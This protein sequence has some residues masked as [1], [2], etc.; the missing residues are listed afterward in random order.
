M[1]KINWIILLIITLSTQL[2]SAQSKVTLNVQDMTAISKL[3]KSRSEKSVELISKQVFLDSVQKFRIEAYL[4]SL[5][6]RFFMDLRTKNYKMIQILYKEY[7]ILKNERNAYLKNILTEYQF[8]NF[9]V[10]Q[11]KV[12]KAEFERLKI[13]LNDK[14]VDN[15]VL[16]QTLGWDLLGQQITFVDK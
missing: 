8:N 16:I 12:E 3:A 6:Q 7:L 14:S 15:Q 1:K 2:A 9:L 5:E 4:Y 13:N 10:L 11:A